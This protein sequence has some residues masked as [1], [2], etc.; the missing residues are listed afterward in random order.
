MPSFLNLN[1]R[2]GGDN[3][4]ARYDEELGGLLRCLRPRGHRHRPVRSLSVYHVAI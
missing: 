2:R 3:S 4:V 1:D